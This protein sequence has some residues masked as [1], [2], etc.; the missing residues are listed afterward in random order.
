MVQVQCQDSGLDIG[1]LMKPLMLKAAFTGQGELNLDPLIE[2]MVQEKI[3]QSLLAS[4]DIPEE[5]AD[6]VDVICLKLQ[7]NKL[8]GLTAALKGEQV[9]VG[10][11]DDVINI[12]VQLQMLKA[13]E[14]AFG[15]G[16]T[17]TQ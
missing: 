8:K 10:G 17:G 3:E 9:E 12:V 1:A 5:F 4:I 15:G 14:G 6:L 2:L 13:L 11:L 16:T 7:M